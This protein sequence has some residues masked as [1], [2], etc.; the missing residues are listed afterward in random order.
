VKL[1]S[2]VYTLIH[3]N[4][5]ALETS[6]TCHLQYFLPS[7]EAASLILWYNQKLWKSDGEAKAGWMMWRKQ[8]VLGVTSLYK[9]RSCALKIG[10]GKSCLTLC[11]LIAVKLFRACEIKHDYIE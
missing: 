9:M 5:S 7:V 2:V 4:V 3:L 6:S 1:P 10:S 8:V 11:E